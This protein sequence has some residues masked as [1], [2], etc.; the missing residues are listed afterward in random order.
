MSDLVKRLRK[1]DGRTD[2]GVTEEAADCIV[3]LKA[4]E[5][6]LAKR[7][8][9]AVRHLPKHP[10]MALGFLLGDEDE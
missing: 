1:Y 6:N 8:D 10:G 4:R 5:K 7:I 9:K 3:E 2:H